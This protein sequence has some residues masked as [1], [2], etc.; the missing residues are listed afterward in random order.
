MSKIVSWVGT[1]YKK[2]LW[3]AGEPMTPVECRAVVA[4]GYDPWT[5]HIRRSKKRLGDWWWLMVVATI[6]VVNFKAYTFIKNKRWG[7]LA[8]TVLLD[9]LFIWLLPHVLGVW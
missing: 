1:A 8:V 5:H 4:A 6:L 7:W 2:L 3:V 9:G